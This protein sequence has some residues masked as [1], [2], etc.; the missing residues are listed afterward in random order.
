MSLTALRRP[1]GAL[2]LLVLVGTAPAEGLGPNIVAGACSTLSRPEDVGRR[3]LVLAL[4]RTTFA[5]DRV[6][7]ATVQLKDPLKGGQVAEVA[8]AAP[9]GAEV[10]V[11]VRVDNPDAYPGT[12]EPLVGSLVGFLAET[13]GWLLK[14]DV[15]DVVPSELRSLELPEPVVPDTPAP[16]LL[17][18]SAHLRA[19]DVGQ[20]TFML[21]Y[22]AANFGPFGSYYGVDVT[23]AEPL[24]QDQLEAIRS[25]D[26]KSL[27]L[28]VLE[29]DH[30]GDPL[31]VRARLHGMGTYKGPFAGHFEDADLPSFQLTPIP[32]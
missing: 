11:Y 7:A 32:R 2:L 16:R 19:E 29:Y 25:S 9:P 13:G 10:L 17:A 12:H 30:E 31:A 14:R 27:F 20:T 5:H 1:L 3:Q 24:R 4:P 22:P 18:G 26:G 21:S 23:L 8:D 15:L 28:E 6:F